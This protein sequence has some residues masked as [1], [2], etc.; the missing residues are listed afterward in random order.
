MNHTGRTA[1]GQ[2]TYRPDFSAL[3]V[4]SGLADAMS[5]LR[6][7]LGDDGYYAWSSTLPT[8]TVLSN[9]KYEA[10]IRA[11]LV[12]VVL[13]ACTQDTTPDGGQS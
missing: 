9:A 6:A 10:A 5:Q 8:S 11:R 12:E 3:H 1:S 2:F 7:A 4:S 13:G